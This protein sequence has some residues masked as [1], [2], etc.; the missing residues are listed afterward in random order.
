[1]AHDAHYDGERVHLCLQWNLWHK[2]KNEHIMK[3]TNLGPLCLSLAT[4]PILA[5]PLW[6]LP[7]PLYF[8]RMPLMGKPLEESYSGEVETLWIKFVMSYVD[9]N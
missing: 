2:F 4:T 1:M 6:A 5:S 8:L 9:L 7:L 3:V